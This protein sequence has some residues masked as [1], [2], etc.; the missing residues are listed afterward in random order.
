MLLVKRLVAVSRFLKD[1]HQDRMLHAARLGFR[2]TAMISALALEANHRNTGVPCQYR[3]VARF[4]Q[5]PC[6]D[7]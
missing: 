1:R 4:A 7:I 5:H 3:E 2:R 6:Q